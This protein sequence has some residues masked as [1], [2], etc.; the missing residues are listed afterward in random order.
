MNTE[1]STIM[2]MIALKE[3]LRKEVWHGWGWSPEKRTDFEERK[4]IILSAPQLKK[5]PSSIGVRKRTHMNV[6]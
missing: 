4:L 6:V 5:Q 1:Q 2:D 3:G